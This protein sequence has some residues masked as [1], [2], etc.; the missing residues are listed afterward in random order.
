MQGQGVS[1][2][3]LSISQG[4]LVERNDRI[5]VATGRGQKVA[6]VTAQAFLISLVVGDKDN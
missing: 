6:H 3:F 5:I 4:C 2:H 1:H